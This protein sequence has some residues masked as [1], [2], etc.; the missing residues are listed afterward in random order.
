FGCRDPFFDFLPQKTE[1]T[2]RNT[3]QS[4]NIS[5]A[6]VLVKWWRT[7]RCTK[8]IGKVFVDVGDGGTD[9]EAT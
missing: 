6:A 1:K 4:K 3:A 5:R 9:G 7:I 8:E 2:V